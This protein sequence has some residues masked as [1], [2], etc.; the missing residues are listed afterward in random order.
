MMKRFILLIFTLFSFTFVFGQFYSESFESDLGGWTQLTTDDFDWT[1]NSGTTP[2]DGTGPSSASDG[3]YYLFVEANNNHENTAIIERAIS[4]ANTTMPILSFDYHLY[5]SGVGFLTLKIYDGTSWTTVWNQINEQGNQW[6]N[7]KLC[8][9]D[10]AD[11]ANVKLRFIADVQYTDSSDIAIDNI[12]IV[13]F[14]YTSVSKTDVTCGGYSDGSINITIAGG[15]GTYEY[16]K[17]N[18]NAYTAPG[19]STTQ[20]FSSLPGGGYLLKVRDVSGCVIDY[21]VVNI[22][23]PETNGLSANKTDVSPCV[24]SKNGDITITATGINSP[25]TY[26]VS[27]FGGPFQASNSFTSLDTGDYEIAVRNSVGCIAVGSVIEINC[28]TRI[29]IYDE[30]ATDVSTCFGDCNGAVNLSVGGGNTPL[31]YAIDT[32]ASLTFENSSDFLGLC[33][34]TYSVIIEDNSGC[35]VTTNDLTVNEPALLT[36][37]G[38]NHTDILGC[39]GD[40]T[41]TISLSA[42]G[43]TGTINYSINNG[44]NYQSSGNFSDLAAGKYYIWA[45]DVN[46]CLTEKDSIS[47]TQ[48][49]LLVLDSAIYSDVTGCYGDANGEIHIYAQ[50][51]T[52]SLEYSID[53]EATYLSSNDFI[54][55]D[56]GDYN[57]F[58]RDNNGCKDSASLITISQPSSLVI[59]NISAYD[60]DNCY[61]GNTGSIQIFAAQGTEPYEY[62]IDNGTTYQSLFTFSNVSAGNHQIIVR[63]DNGCTKVLDSLVEINQPAEIVISDQIATDVL[64]NGS[65]DGTVYVN[66]SGGTGSLLYSIDNSITFPYSVGTLTYLFEGSYQIAV[67]DE[68]GCTVNGN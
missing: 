66:A 67:K 27:G 29:I 49:P 43:G 35:R 26:S 9:D 19:T 63:D 32:S 3:S 17:D 46:N 47:L 60:V 12:E 11:N 5:G 59:T 38:K 15:F 56:V 68:N 64:C 52:P 23:E 24:D 20:L 28:P 54:N 61:G 30:T 48:P 21:P 22:S 7:V 10:Y 34:G 31:S 62:S 18:G 58:V 8:L 51:G 4:F 2:T 39:Y 6:N 50:G 36:Y 25:F 40:E 42:V 14:E 45:R 41:G 53:G 57:A 44:T 65:D 37:T 1:R 33:A 55:L 16:S 13:D